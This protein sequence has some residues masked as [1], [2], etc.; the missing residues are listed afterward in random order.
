MVTYFAVFCALAICVGELLVKIYEW[1]QDF[2]YGLCIS[3]DRLL[4]KN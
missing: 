3:R 4:Q 1:R 2:L